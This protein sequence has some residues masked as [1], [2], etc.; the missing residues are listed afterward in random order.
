MRILSG[1]RVN[2]GFG[3][4]ARFLMQGE[5]VEAHGAGHSLTMGEAAVGFQQLI[6]VTLGHF[7][8]I[9][10]DV[11]VLDLEGG[12][13]CLLSIF[14]FKR[15]DCPARI[16]RDPAQ[17]VQRRVIAGGDISALSPLSGRRRHQRPFEMIHQR[18]MAAEIGQQRFK[19][20][21]QILPPRKP[22]RSHARTGK[23]IAKLTEIAGRASARNDPAQRAAHVRQRTQGGTHVLTQQGIFVEP[24]D[25]F[26]PLCDGRAVRQRRG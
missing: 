7:D 10:E 21:R 14:C 26:Q 20:H 15:G 19:Q 16:A 24:L 23:T 17:F 5:R 1:K 11:V 2:A 4:A 25:Q 22:I 8:E 18:A 6:R 3:D 12:D 9:A 13:A